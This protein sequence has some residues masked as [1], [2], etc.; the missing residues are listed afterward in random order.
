VS[1]PALSTKGS[2]DG[3]NHKEYQILEFTGGP[4]LTVSEMEG[5][6]KVSS[7]NVKG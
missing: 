7:H 3:S 4:P 5:R 1:C 6:K 2:A